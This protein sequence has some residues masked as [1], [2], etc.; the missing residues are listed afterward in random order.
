MRADGNALTFVDT[1]FS[2]A[3]LAS[4]VA[5][6]VDGVRAIAVQPIA[7]RSIYTTLARAIRDRSISL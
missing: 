2:E 3:D 7:L 6:V 5:S 1:R 4:R